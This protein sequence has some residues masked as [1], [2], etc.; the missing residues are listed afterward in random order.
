MFEHLSDSL[1]DLITNQEFC[2]YICLHAG[3]P[4]VESFIV[5]C[6]IAVWLVFFLLKE[7]MKS[8]L[9]TKSEY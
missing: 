1:L 3:S 2:Y 5:I 6:Q 4:K 7:S 9:Q 8:Y